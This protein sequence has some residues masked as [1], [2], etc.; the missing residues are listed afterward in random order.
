MFKII[1]ISTVLTTALCSTSGS[2]RNVRE[3][4]NQLRNQLTAGRRRNLDARINALGCPSAYQGCPKEALRVDGEVVLRQSKHCF[5]NQ[6]CDRV[7]HGNPRNT[8]GNNSGF[9]CVPVSYPTNGV[10]YCCDDHSYTSTQDLP[11]CGEPQGR[12]QGRVQE[13]EQQVSESMGRCPNN[14]SGGCRRRNSQGTLRNGEHQGHAQEGEQQVRE[15]IGRCPNSGSGGCPVNSL[16]AAE[17]LDD[18]FQHCVFNHECDVVTHGNP[19]NIA[20]DSGFYCI[21]VSY[22]TRQHKYCCDH[23]D[24]TGTSDLPQCS[25]ALGYPSSDQPSEEE[26]HWFS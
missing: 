11:R 24:Y 13:R 14:G 10:K 19:M 6:Q 9:F 17:R 22:S 25:D 4:L 8:G 15:L 21:P 5:I 12:A 18:Q 7:T 26:S 23:P 20:R 16:R 1:I 2:R 3:T